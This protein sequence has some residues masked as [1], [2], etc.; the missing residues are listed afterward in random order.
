MAIVFIFSGT[1]KKITRW[2]GAIGLFKFRAQSPLTPWFSFILFV[3]YYM[4]T[5]VW[6]DPVASVSAGNSYDLGSSPRSSIFPCY[7]SITIHM[8]AQY[9]GSPYTFSIKPSTRPRISNQ[10]LRS[11]E[12]KA[13]WSAHIHMSG[14]VNEVR[15]VWAW[16]AWAIPPCWGLQPP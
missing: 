15:L 14:K 2:Q 13:P 6:V 11:K 1:K 4:L 8:Q 10:R 9:C 3:C 7:F 12:H 5:R 16:I